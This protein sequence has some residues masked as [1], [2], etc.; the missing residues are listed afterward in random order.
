ML[1]LPLALTALAF[2]KSASAHFPAPIHLQPRAHPVNRRQI[3][4]DT[5]PA[6]PLF[7]VPLAQKQDTVSLSK[8]FGTPSFLAGIEQTGQEIAQQLQAALAAG[9]QTRGCP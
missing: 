8:D 3:N 9:K 7:P 6:P 5:S 1:P 2:F 4:T